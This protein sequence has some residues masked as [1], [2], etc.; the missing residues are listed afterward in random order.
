[1]LEL[2][3]PY[4]EDD[5][6]LVLFP[7]ASVPVVD[8][9][10]ILG[11]FE[12]HYDVTALDVLEERLAAYMSPEL[13]KGI[14]SDALLLAFGLRRERRESMA[15]GRLESRRGTADECR[16][17]ALLAASCRHDFDLAEQV[18]ASLS[19]AHSRP[20]VALAFDIARRL[21]AAGLRLDVPDRRLIGPA[22]VSVDVEVHVERV[23]GRPDRRLKNDG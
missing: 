12:E 8:I 3:T 1:M 7:P 19:V 21:E 17:L 5:T 10:R 18:A 2:A 4:G 23:Q 9:F 22:S 16:L 15:Y 11:D 20:V 14:V 13:A 6:V